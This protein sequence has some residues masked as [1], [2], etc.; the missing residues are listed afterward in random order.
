MSTWGQKN[1]Q[2]ETFKKLPVMETVNGHE[3]K[4]DPESQKF[5]VL[6]EDRMILR[7]SIQPI[8]KLCASINLTAPIPG[9]RIHEYWPECPVEEPVM[10]VAAEKNRLR[11]RGG[12][13]FPETEKVYHYDQEIVQELTRIYQENEETRKRFTSQWSETCQ[14]LV[15]I[16]PVEVASNATVSAVA[17][18]HPDQG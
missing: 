18:E 6:L 15:R 1:R 8:R 14:R 10:I 2:E 3:V 9:F 7:A 11:T 17:P 12:M 5:M 16:L 4:Y 13:L